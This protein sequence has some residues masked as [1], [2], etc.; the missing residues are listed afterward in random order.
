MRNIRATIRR[1][2]IR[3]AIILILLLMASLSWHRG[4]I[5]SDIDGVMMH[6]GQM[7]LM[8]A[9]KPAGPMASDLTMSNGTKVTTSGLVIMSD[10]TRAQMSN[11]EMIMMDGKI[12]EGGKATGMV[13]Q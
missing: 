7:M 12:M 8:K 6:D 4:A 10:G 5:A 1:A 13:N 3:R 2:T 11:G 9:G